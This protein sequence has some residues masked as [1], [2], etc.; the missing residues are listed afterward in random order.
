MISSW[1]HKQKAKRFL[2]H[3]FKMGEMGITYSYGNTS[4]KIY[5]KIQAVTL[6]KETLE[7][8]F[9]LPTGMD[10][11]LI[12]K[13][14]FC[15]RQ[16]FGE[17]I[18]LKG[19]VKKFTLTVYVSSVPSMVRY[20]KEQF[21]EQMENK[22]LPIVCGL[23]MKGKKVAYDMLKYPHLLIAG[24]TGTG[25]STQLR[26]ILTSLIST[27]PPERLELYLCD[28]KRSEFHI[29]RNVKQV[30]AVA[31]NPTDMLPML[32][33]L[34]QELNRRGDLLDA[35]ELAHIDD[36]PEPLPYI[37]LCI[38]EVARLKKER[39]IMDMIEEIS[40][41]G[42]ALGIL[43][44]LSMQRPDANLLDGALK[45]NLTVRMGFKCA[46][47]INSKIIGTPG[48]EKLPGDGRM[49]LKLDGVDNLRE[50]QAPF[51]PLEKAKI[52]LERYKYPTNKKPAERKYEPNNNGSNIIDA[53]FEVL[54]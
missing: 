25:K 14:Q 22:R 33:Y 15:F 11:K 30:K 29:F 39:V 49:L 10:P 51:L 1:L 21:Q 36:L 37:V 24:E 44:I 35:H 20:D 7:Y 9:T 52:I 13:Q 4:G 48:S 43:L 19:D 26:S 34:Q 47:L 46:D 54:D 42:R 18:E 2:Q 41:V 32:E 6:K 3:A 38:D 27:L 31:V 17:R 28:M 16:V 8:V 53:I 40:A 50:I 45:N 23:D 5:P 12:T